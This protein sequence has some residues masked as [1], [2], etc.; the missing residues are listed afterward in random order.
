MQTTQTVAAC[1]LDELKSATCKVVSIAGKTI[2]VVYDDGRVFALDNR[3]PHMG[4]PLH[5]GTVRDG[6]LTCHWHHAKFDL[7]SGC[8]LD[9]FADDTP[10]FAVEVRDGMVYVD[11]R[12]REP[13]RR[14]HWTR[15]LQE[16][17]QQDLPLV[18]AK[19]VIGLV[20]LGAVE[21]I[22]TLTAEFGLTNRAAGWSTGLTILTAMATLLPTLAPE[23]RRLALYHGLVHVARS[24]ANQ[25][26]HFDLGPLAT[27]ETTATRYLEWFRQFIDSRSAEAA[28]RTLRTAIHMNLPQDTIATM[29]FAACT[30]HL[31]LDE[32]HTLDFANKAF[33]LLDHIGWQHADAV[34]PALLPHL[35]SADRAEERESWRHP[36]DTPALLSAAYAE[37]EAWITEGTRHPQAWSGHEA[38]AEHI[39][40][41][42]PA[43]MLEA[44]A[45]LIRDGVPLRELASTVAYAGAKRLVHFHVSNEFSDWNTVHHTFTYANAVDQAIRRAPSPLVARGILDGAMSVYLERFLN[46]PKQPAPRPSGRPRTA[47]DLLATFDGYGHVEEAAAIVADLLATKHHD[48]VVTALGHALLREDAGFHQFQIYEAGV[49]QYERF[50][51]S[52]LG[53]DV[54]IGVT[55]FLAAHSPT[56]RATG[57]TFRTAERLH[58]GEALHAEP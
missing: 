5:R 15:K 54:L 6:I 13:D 2:L 12:P 46:V 10:S 51:H 37:L 3:C 27:G 32:G 33:E 35:V 16:G 39:L 1:A 30:D 45:R 26:P 43:A 24:T 56:V 40:D 49:R 25:A 50:A 58:R 11:P 17:L 48:Q 52:R 20:E 36:V 18:L 31:Y 28:E 41:E 34:L 42:E 29:L 44:M 55:R 9:P 38:L 23:D 53:D 57:Q 7:S 4:F 14:I 22:L 8:T 21:D 19:S 47:A